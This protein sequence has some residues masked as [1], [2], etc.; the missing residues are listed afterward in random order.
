MPYGR[1]AQPPQRYS[2]S[3]LSL[4]ERPLEDTLDIDLSLTPATA[5]SLFI[6]IYDNPT[7]EATSKSVC[8]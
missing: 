5:G 3:L 6:D 7:A 1:Y 8:G 2:V 4:V